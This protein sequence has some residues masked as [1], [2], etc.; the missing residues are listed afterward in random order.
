MTTQSKPVK[1]SLRTLKWVWI[2]FL[3]WIV[4]GGTL[5]AV[6]QL[7]GFIEPFCDMDGTGD[8]YQPC[9][10]CRM[11]GS[12]FGVFEVNPCKS[13]LIKKALEYGIALPRLMIAFL[14]FLVYPL[15]E[16][17][18]SLHRSLPAIILLPSVAALL[19]RS[20]FMNFVKR[21]DTERGLHRG[22]LIGWFG[23]S[24]LLAV[25]W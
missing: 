22:F 20:L 16:L 18:S 4:I 8:T 25:Q 7:T 19:L 23:L 3:G 17:L 1:L 11:H 10:P 21:K 6:L 24:T 12:A 2:A 9:T 15:V 13:S 14:T 5:G